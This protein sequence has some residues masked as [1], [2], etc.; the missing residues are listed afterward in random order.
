MYFVNRLLIKMLCLGD[1]GMDTRKILS[2]VIVTNTAGSG[3]D[4]LIYL[5][6]IHTTNNY[7]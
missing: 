4:D 1:L 3:F 7:T 6:L 5:H 2:C